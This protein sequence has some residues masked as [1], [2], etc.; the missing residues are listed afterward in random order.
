MLNSRDDDLGRK[1]KAP[2]KEEASAPGAE[3]SKKGK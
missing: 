2:E 1:R 3:S